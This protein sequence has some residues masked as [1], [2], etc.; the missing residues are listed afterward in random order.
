MELYKIISLLNVFII[1]FI[2]FIPSFFILFKKNIYKNKKIFIK[3]IS[4]ALIIEII[5]FVLFHFFAE[6]IINLVSSKTNIQNY[7]LYCS[8]IL[9][10]ASSIT[11]LH[12]AI[13]LYFCFNENIKKGIKLFLLKFLYLPIMFLGYLIFNTKGIY[14][15]VP[16]CDILYTFFLLFIF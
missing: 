12:F 1:Y 15:S 2:A 3:K 9:F 10:I 8:K 5:I 4:L 7:T 11:V 6:N 14:F 13:P 16:L